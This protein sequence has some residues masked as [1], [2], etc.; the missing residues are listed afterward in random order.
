MDDSPLLTV[1]IAAD[2][3]ADEIVCTAIG[4]LDP[5]TGPQLDG[6]VRAA[7]FTSEA[8]S[9]VLDLSGIGFMDSSGLR[10]VIDLHILMRERNG[11]LVLRHPSATIRRLL[12]ITNLTE[13]FTIED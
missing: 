5:R 10:I 2:R 6:E 4:E 7:V 11:R 3:G 9:L 13:T 1:G 8:K 12:E